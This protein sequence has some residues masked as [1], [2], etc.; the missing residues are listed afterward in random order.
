[1]KQL[2]QPKKVGTILSCTFLAFMLCAMTLTAPIY[3]QTAI[4]A[5][6]YLDSTMQKIEGFGA[7]NIIGWRP[8]MTAAEVQ[9]AFGTSANQ[10]GFTLLRLRIAPDSTQ[11]AINVASALAAQQLGARIIASPWTPPAWMKTNNNTVGGY[12]LPSAYA[13][14]AAH[15][16]SFVDT[17]AKYGVSIYAVSLQN[18]PDASVSYESCY[19]TAT[20]FLNFVKYYAPAIGTPIF[21]PESESFVHALSDSTLNDSAACANVGFVA[22]HLY[23]VSPTTYSLAASKGKEV[24]MTEHYTTS[25]DSGNVWPL[26]LNVGKEISDCMNANMSAYVWWYIVRFYGPI[27][28]NGNPTKRGYVMSHFSQFIFPGSVRV[29]SSV[30]SSRGV[31]SISVSAFK[32]SNQIIIEA[33]NLN[34][35]TI[36][37]SIILQNLTG[38]AASFT[39]YVTSQ[40]K[41]VLYQG[42]VAASN[43]RLVDTLEANCIAT[44]VSNATSGV[45]NAPTVPS[46]FS[47]AQNYPNPFNPTTRI[48]FTL[49][50]AA[51]VKLDIYNIL[52][53]KVATLINNEYQQGG[54]QSVI[55]DASKLS[56]GMYF[57]KLE[58]GSF[59]QT[60]KMLLLK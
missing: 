33:I 37:D 10:L 4:P 13:A 29:Y 18:E 43:S 41:N 55:F 57:Y 26:A 25:T 46:T 44:Y 9:T 16:K 52:G 35:S 24:W 40:S 23:G 42:T 8:D 48:D 3:A 58:A 12:L 51:Y 19:W 32:S 59:M 39:K 34:S 17:M 27:D 1:M 47:L 15:L 56:S 5:T 21:M 20:Q 30:S 6:V 7:A 11:F 53:Q 2:V 31:P 36:R 14:Y 54:Q 50:K 38:G 28:E 49:G 22:G 60:R 45:K